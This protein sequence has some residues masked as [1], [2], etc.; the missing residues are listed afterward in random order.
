[1]RAHISTAFGPQARGPLRSLATLLLLGAMVGTGQ[2][3]L[4]LWWLALLAFGAVLALLARAPDALRGVWLGW[5]AGVGYSLATLFWIV[6]PFFVDAARHGWMAPFALVLMAAGMGLFW[7]LASGVGLRLARPSQG[8]RLLALATA[9]A[10][11]DLVRSYIFT[12][13]PWALLGHV[14]IDTPMMQAAALIGPVG[15]SA[16]FTG[17]GAALGA[18]VLWRAG[19]AARITVAAIAGFLVSVVWVWGVGRLQAPDPSP[20]RDIVVRLVQPNAAQH[21][22]WQ[23]GMALEFFLRHL[24]LT[25]APAE[26]WPDLIVWPETAVPFLLDDPG[27]GLLM[28]SEAARGAPVALG[29]Q[30]SEGRRYF[31]SLAIIG[32]DGETGEVYDKFHLT[33]FGEYIPFGDTLARIGVSAFAAQAGKGYSAGPGAVVLDLGPLGLVQ[34]LICYEAVFPQDLRAA[35]RRPDWVLQVTNDSWFGR[36]SGPYQHLAQAQLRAVEMGLPFARAANTGVSAMIDPRGRIVAALGLDTQGYLDVALPAALP[37]TPYSRMGDWP[38][39]VLIVAGLGLL[40]RLRANHVDP[41]RR[42]G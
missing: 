8:W 32:P 38:I 40:A 19:A 24:E 3:P 7:A 30:R 5:A 14:W 27:S 4:G 42:E 21:L 41:T 10:G 31:N 29:I 18:A 9:F 23:P 26:R 39:L 35:P 12:G 11:S 33:P 13:F 28:I 20:T 2:A 1:M 36:L 25:S 6:E 37:A 22:K 15:L 34:P 16:L 17:A